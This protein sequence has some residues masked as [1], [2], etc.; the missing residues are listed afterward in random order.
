[1]AK[2]IVRGTLPWVLALL[3][4]GMAGLLFTAVPGSG[5]A[6]AKVPELASQP[7]LRADS[8]DLGANEIPSA[9]VTVC[10]PIVLNGWPPIP[11]TPVLAP[12]GN[13]DQDNFYTVS[14]I[15]PGGADSVVLEEAGNAAFSQ[16]REVFR[17]IASNW[18]V[19]DPGKTP[20]TYYYR[21]KARNVWGDGAWSSPQ[22]VT[23]YPMFVGL[24]LR[25]DGE[26]YLRGDDYYDVGTHLTRTFAVLTALDII[27]AHSRGWYDPNPLGWPELEWDGYY[28]VS[29][30]NF[31]AGSVPP[32]PSWKW[33]YDM[34]LPY[35]VDLSEGQMVLIDNQAFD[36]SGPIAGHTAFGQPVQYWQLVNSQEFLYWDGGGDWTQRVH[37]GDI[38]LWYDAGATR[39]LI[40]SNVLRR[41]Y[42]Q[43]KPENDTIQY[44][45]YLTY[46]NSFPG[47]GSSEAGTARRPR[48]GLPAPQPQLRLPGLGAGWKPD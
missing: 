27:L 33:G 4:L 6:K 40:M 10:L 44:I 16:A 29:T 20:G 24:E 7:P 2:R 31:I 18:T 42:Y 9:S 38:T 26:G 19:P 13:A 3:T 21:L 43:G 15:W 34:L 23:V 22:Q 32:D 47:T 12:I 14:W 17:G 48:A 46:A 41:Y 39:L 28:S 8:T 5:P 35:D 45:Q 36:V 25:W 37:A 1:V 11:E 30:G